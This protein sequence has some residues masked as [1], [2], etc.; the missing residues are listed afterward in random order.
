LLANGTVRGAGTLD[1][2][3]AETRLPAGRLE[4]IFLALT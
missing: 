3:R 2:L 1:H 4:D